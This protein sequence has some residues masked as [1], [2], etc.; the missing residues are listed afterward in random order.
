MAKMARMDG[1]GVNKE[2]QASIE[3]ID[4]IQNNLD[5]LTEKASAEILQVEQKYNKLRQPYYTKRGEMIKSIPNFWATVF[6][7]HPQVS[8]I[9]GEEDE[10]CLQYLISISVEEFEDIKSGY[11]I[12]FQFKKNPYFSN[13]EIEKEFHL[14]DDEIPSG[15]TS[16]VIKWL[17]GKSLVAKATNGAGGKRKNEE[18]QPTFFTW[19][20][21]NPDAGMDEIGEA[22]KDEIWPNPLQFY[23]GNMDEDVDEDDLEDEG[24]EE[25][26]EGDEEDEEGEGEDEEDLEE[27]DE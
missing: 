7:N 21:D 11:K 25:D 20:S 15:P 22:I 19:F 26:E 3:K 9:L 12:K 27:E 5:S 14:H 6:I 18:T 23:L 1:E 2:V 10:D 16:T 24:G 8:A 17:P 4:E 13:D